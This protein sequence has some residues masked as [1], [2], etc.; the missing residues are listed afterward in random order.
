MS[1]TNWEVEGRS[2][3]YKKDYLEALED[4]KKILKIKE[5]FNLHDYNSLKSLI[6]EI[7]KKTFQFH[8]LVGEDFIDE[9]YQKYDEIRSNNTSS[10]KSKNATHKKKSNSKSKVKKK[11]KKTKTSKIISIEDFDE[12]MQA[13]IKAEMKRKEQRRTWIIVASML[14]AVVSL[15]YFFIYDYMEKRST[16]NAEEWSKLKDQSNDMQTEKEFEFVPNLIVD[17]VDVDDLEVLEEYKVLIEKNKTLIGWIKIDDTY[18]D[19]PVM[20]AADNEYYLSHNFNQEKDNNGCIF[21]DY[22]SDFVNRDT[23]LIIYGHNM[24]SGKMFGSLR[25]YQDEEYYLEHSTIQFDTIYEKG[26]YEIMYVFHGQIHKEE[27]IAFKYYQFFD[28]KSE[29]E[30][31][32]YMDSM[33]EISLYNTGVTATYGDQLLT[34]STCDTGGDYS[35]R[36]VVV[37]KRIK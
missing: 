34:L 5:Q 16:S 21:L 33:D 26:T 25:K 14:V 20:Q 11:D 19:Y 32:Y 10:K 12:N 31:N 18:I 30:F 27:D 24:K 6:I 36:F 29:V 37:A 13:H 22:Q 1:N 35:T 9:V 28:A 3:Q 4:K 2:F 7:E 8:T 17:E 23:N 15:S